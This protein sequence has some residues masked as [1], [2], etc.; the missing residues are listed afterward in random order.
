MSR[1]P[2]SEERL[3]AL[4]TMDLAVLVPQSAAWQPST[5]RQAARWL[6]LA[7][8]VFT[9]LLDEID[10]LD[11]E[12]E[13]TDD[14]LDTALARL[15]RLRPQV[16]ASDAVISAVRRERLHDRRW[17]VRWCEDGLRKS[18]TFRLPEHAREAYEYLREQQ[19]RGG[20]R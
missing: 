7:A 8:P 11:D 14:E 2:I 20:A 17:R 9:E 1:E 16:P 19:Y 10:E 18:Q 3:A 4:R 5:R 15:R 12:L 13:L 6:R